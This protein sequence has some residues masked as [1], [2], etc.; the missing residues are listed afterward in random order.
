MKRLLAILAA[1]ILPFAA[2]SASYTNSFVRNG[3]TYVQ[4]GGLTIRD[5]VITNID[6]NAIG[7]SMTTNDVK[8]IVTN[9]SATKTVPKAKKVALIVK[10]S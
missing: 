2:F 3:V 4:R 9:E 7:S 10:R 1:I 5:Y 6:E 8:N